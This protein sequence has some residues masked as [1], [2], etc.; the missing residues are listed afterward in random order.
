VSGLCKL[1]CCNFKR[2]LF[3]LF[4]LYTD[5]T[6]HF[7]YPFYEP[8]WQTMELREIGQNCHRAKNSKVQF[9]LKYHGI[10]ACSEIDVPKIH[11]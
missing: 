2:I 8:Y 7:A 10:E 3:T 5:K 4:S 1:W 9:Q 11:K 6:K